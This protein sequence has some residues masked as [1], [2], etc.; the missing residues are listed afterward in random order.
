MMRAESFVVLRRKPV[1]VSISVLQYWCDKLSPYSLHFSVVDYIWI[2]FL[3]AKMVA[4]KTVMY[5]RLQI[6]NICY[7]AILPLKL[8]I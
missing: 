8:K 1:E 6:Y 5:K 2:I 3:T 4:T 7:Q